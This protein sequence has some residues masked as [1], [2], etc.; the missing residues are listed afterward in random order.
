MQEDKQIRRK[1]GIY[2]ER[3]VGTNRKIGRYVE[4]QVDMYRKTGI[5]MQKVQKDL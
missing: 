4:R 1:K 5:E 2:V 3:Q